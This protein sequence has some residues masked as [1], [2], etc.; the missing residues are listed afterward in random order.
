MSVAN[1]KNIDDEENDILNSPDLV[2]SAEEK[3]IIS[4]YLAQQDSTTTTI[5]DITIVQTNNTDT[6]Q[7]SYEH[8]KINLVFDKPLTTDQK[9][10][11]VEPITNTSEN[12]QGGFIEPN[13]I[14]NSSEQPLQEPNMKEPNNYTNQS[15]TMEVLVKTNNIDETTTNSSE[16]NVINQTVPIVLP[17]FEPK[18]ETDSDMTHDQNYASGEPMNKIVDF[19]APIATDDKKK[20]IATDNADKPIVAMIPNIDEIKQKIVPKVE[21]QQQQRIEIVVANKEEII[22]TKPNVEQSI[23]ITPSRR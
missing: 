7:S 6:N 15:E 18:V 13:I 4:S 11:M 12:V 14:L 8:E 2:I 3:A 16:S 9:Q 19:E 22:I 5:N 23:I 21:E 17:S 1:E 10:P 20:E